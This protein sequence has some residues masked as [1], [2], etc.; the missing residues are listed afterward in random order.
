MLKSTSRGS[1]HH[2]WEAPY[3]Y[4]CWPVHTGQKWTDTYPFRV[5]QLLAT[6]FQY[7]QSCRFP[8][9]SKL[10]GLQNNPKPLTKPFASKQDG[11][12]IAVRLQNLIS[13]TGSYFL[14]IIRILSWWRPCLLRQVNCQLGEGSQLYA[15]LKLRGLPQEEKNFVCVLIQRND[16]I[17]AHQRTVR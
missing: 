14:P 12:E 7:A 3:W 15:G 6:N 5:T 10:P 2:K 16:R 1:S 4:E 9:N 8:Q 11:E 13:K 17:K